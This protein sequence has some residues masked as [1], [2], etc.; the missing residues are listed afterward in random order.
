MSEYASF[1]EIIGN[2]PHIINNDNLF[3]IQSYKYFNDKLLQL[4][5]ANVPT[6]SVSAPQ[7]SVFKNNFGSKPP[8]FNVPNTGSRDRNSSVF[9]INYNMDRSGLNSKKEEDIDPSSSSQHIQSFR[10]D[11]TDVIMDNVHP[12]NVN[13][14]RRTSVYAENIYPDTQIINET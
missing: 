8:S 5:A 9:K 11:S 6:N 10:Q 12:P 1:Q 3:I 2:N 7:A 13:V 14:N 4:V